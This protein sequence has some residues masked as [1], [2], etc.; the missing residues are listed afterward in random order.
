MSRDRTQG[1]QTRTYQRLPELF[2]LP[3]QRN[4]GH[5]STFSQVIAR[6]ESVQHLSIT[7]TY[8]PKITHTGI[9]T[10]HKAALTSQSSL[11]IQNTPLLF[12]RFIVETHTRV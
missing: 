1:Y 5:K 7:I 11:F 9:K 8:H 10:K 12:S 2:E 3:T 4:L 6:L